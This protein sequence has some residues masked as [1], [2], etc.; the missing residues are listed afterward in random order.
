MRDFSR[1]P[2]KACALASRSSSKASVV[3]MQPPGT[4]LASLRAYPV[5]WKRGGWRGLG[6][7]ANTGVVDWLLACPGKGFFVSIVSESTDSL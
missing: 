2:V 6:H 4:I 1:K 7:A 5:G 3:R